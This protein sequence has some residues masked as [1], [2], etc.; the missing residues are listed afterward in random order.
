LWRCGPLE[1]ALSASIWRARACA[2]E[3]GIDAVDPWYDT[4]PCDG[5]LRRPYIARM[6]VEYIRYRIESA[7]A[8]DFVS[9][10]E[11]ASASLKAS[12]HCSGYELTQ[13][14]EAREHW[15]LRIEWDSEE[16]HLKGF[17]TSAEFKTF[18]A[19]VRPFVEN[20]EEMRHYELTSLRWSR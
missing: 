4:Y 12:S 1:I 2:V 6:I 19:A 10:Y 14:T 7:R 20:I 9:A 15:I 13:C 16:G 18:F 11:T 5:W 3:I 17:R 8:K